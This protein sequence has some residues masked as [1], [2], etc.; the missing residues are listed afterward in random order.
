MEQSGKQRLK[1][2][3]FG[4]PPFAAR[5]LEALLGGPHP[6]AAVVTR[7][8]KPAGR[9]MVERPS[10][11]KTL[12]LAHSLPVLA[13][14]SAKGPELCE[15]IERYRPDLGV[16]VAY[17]RILPADV[18]AAA[19]L[20]FIN[21]HASLLPALRGAAPIERAILEGYRET[22]VTIMQM[23]ERMDAGDII[24]ARTVPIDDEA[25]RETLTSALAEVAAELLPETIEAIARGTARR[26]P[27][28]DSQ[29]T[30][31]PPIDKR[32]AAIDWSEPAEK[33]ARRVRAFRPRPGAY[34]FDNGRRLKIL[35]ARP[36]GGSG[37]PGAVLQTDKEGMLVA[38][39][40]DAVLVSTVQPEGK[41][42]MPAADYLRG[43]KGP[44]LMRLDGGR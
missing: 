13:P 11:V 23:N 3:F 37:Q 43:R 9:G 21:A 36:T 25:D 10:A 8:D 22:G 5:C 6:V 20:G 30:Y 29:A 2:M 24:A 39:G 35:G 40:R 26:T 17:G 32:E 41:R 16:V 4:T 19:P 28:D 27:Q 34:A 18:L 31:A 33:V 42:P 1:L 14:A 12:A 7:P 15:A 44:P 38:C